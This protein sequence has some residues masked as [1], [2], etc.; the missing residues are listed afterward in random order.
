MGYV[1]F[2]GCV[3]LVS[4]LLL[5]TEGLEPLT[6][7]SPNLQK[8]IQQN[9]GLIADATFWRYLMFHASREMGVLHYTKK[10]NK[11]F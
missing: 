10:T 5:V 3:V 8:E 1:I 11:K 9:L 2:C 4:H 6:P 7:T